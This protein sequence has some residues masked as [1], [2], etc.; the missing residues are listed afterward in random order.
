MITNI[1]NLKRA[2]LPLTIAQVT[3]ATTSDVQFNQLVHDLKSPVNS[4]KGIVKLAHTR[5]EDEQAKEYFFMINRCVDKL[6]EKISNTLNMFQKGNDL[7]EID[8]ETLLD[9]VMV[10]LS[11]IDGFE[12]TEFSINIS[13]DGTFYG[14]KPVLESVLQ[15]LLENAVKYRCKDK[16]DCSVT[17]SISDRDNGIRIKVA[18]NGIGIEQDKLPRIFEANFK[19]ILSDEDSHGL[20]LFLVKKAV[21]KMNGSIEVESSVNVGTSFIVDL[22]N[23]LVAAE[24]KTF[25]SVG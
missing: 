8:F 23:T 10:S 22:P 14:L 3:N 17:V 5:I 19:S 9:E 2:E 21:E 18:D 24:H 7:E 4:L 1:P 25:V 16:S 12:N 13:N 15:N 11:H 6:E 20:G